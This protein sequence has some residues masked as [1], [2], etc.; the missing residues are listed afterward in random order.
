MLAAKI[1]TLVILVCCKRKIALRSLIQVFFI[2]FFFSSLFLSL[3]GFDLRN[4]LLLY[5]YFVKK[6]KQNKKSV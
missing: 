6:K 3:V 1:S 4:A 5:R 2:L